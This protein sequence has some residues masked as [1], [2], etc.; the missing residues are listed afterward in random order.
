MEIGKLYQI[1]Q[2][3]FLVYPE[4][5]YAAAAAASRAAEAADAHGAAHGA[6]VYAAFWSK[7]LNCN[8]TFVTPNS[9]FCLIE[10][11]GDYLKVLTTNGELGWIRYPENKKWAKSIEEVAQEEYSFTSL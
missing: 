9:I 10:Q 4:K 11:D 6:A 3:F 7:T 1:K 8:V 2:F 5:T